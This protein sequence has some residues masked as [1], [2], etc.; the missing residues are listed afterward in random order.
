VELIRQ[1][2]PPFFPPTPK[3]A[4]MAYGTVPAPKKAHPLVSR[5]YRI[6]ERA[7]TAQAAAIITIPFELA[8]K[9]ED[10]PT[11]LEDQLRNEFNA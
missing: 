11:G 6:P 7:A 9:N 2:I 4:K 8:E 1:R 5:L 10:V 3:S